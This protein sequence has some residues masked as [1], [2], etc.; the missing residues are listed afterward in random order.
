[1]VNTFEKFSW[2]LKDIQ[3]F[4]NTNTAIYQYKI[5]QF[6]CFHNT[7]N[8][9]CKLIE[10]YEKFQNKSECMINSRYFGKKSKTYVLMSEILRTDNAINLLY[11]ALI[12]WCII[13]CE[14]MIHNVNDDYICN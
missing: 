3:S 8:T 12:W 4:I 13:L 10:A 9:L 11:H 7:T 2:I 14:I 5:C 1:M 6:L